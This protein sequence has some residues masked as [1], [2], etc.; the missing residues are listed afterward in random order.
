MLEL[1]K[2]NPA[3]I[4]SEIWSRELLKTLFQPARENG[5]GKKNNDYFPG[6]LEVLKGYFRNKVIF[7]NWQQRLKKKKERGITKSVTFLGIFTA[8]K[9]WAGQAPHITRLMVDNWCPVMFFMP[10]ITKTTQAG[11]HRSSLSF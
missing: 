10:S 4:S 11:R 6:W 8:R 2:L 7:Q 9:K 1:M 5:E 3:R